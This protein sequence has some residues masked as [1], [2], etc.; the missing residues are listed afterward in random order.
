VEVR[1]TIGN[2]EKRA[3]A[4]NSSGLP[5]GAPAERFHDELSILKKKINQWWLNHM[6]VGSRDEKIV[7]VVLAALAIALVV[8]VVT[9]LV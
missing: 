5:T 6:M 9:L 1:L 3:I 8:A 7:G 2:Q 4:S